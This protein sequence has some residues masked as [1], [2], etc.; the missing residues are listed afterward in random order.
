MMNFLVSIDGTNFCNQASKV[1]QLLGV[2]IN[3][4]KIAIPIIIVLLAILDLGKAV[5]A[6]EEKEIK[7]AQKMLVKRI[8]YG[9]L[10]FFVTTIVQVVFGLIGENITGGNGAACWA[11]ATD[12]NGKSCKNA[13][14]KAVE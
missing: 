6:G 10:I 11:C 7:E 3:I 1:F 12:P 14:S 8:I 9:V 4:L 13:V 5:M 2:V